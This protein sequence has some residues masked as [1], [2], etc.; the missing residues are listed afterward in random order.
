MK[1]FAGIDPGFTGA[2]CLM[3]SGD[4]IRIHDMPV[5]GDKYNCIDLRELVAI[6]RSFPPGTVT[7]LEN[8]TTRPG[9][10]AERCF[11]FGRGIG[12]IEAVLE[13]LGKECKLIAPNLWTG[14][15]GLPGKQWAGAVEQRAVMWD[16]LYPS[17]AGL[18]R[19]PRGGILDGRVD[20]G[21]ITHYLRMVSTSLVG[22]WGKNPP[23][24]LGV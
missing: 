10:G 17:S 12:N 19:G 3:G 9:E 18:I 16:N 5:T 14:K 21:L 6:I 22:K 7:G 8:P 20:A 4:E 1:Y 24:F 2:I 23:K 11:R 13:A 15:L